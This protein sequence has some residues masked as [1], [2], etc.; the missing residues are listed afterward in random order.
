VE[1][2]GPPGY[3]RKGLEEQNRRVRGL[4]ERRAAPLLD[5]EELM[6]KDLRW[7]GDVCYLSG[8]GTERFLQ[9]IAERFAR[10]NRLGK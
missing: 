7:Y 9:N 4:V 8:E 5:Q 2:W 1:L 3:V 6:G 10:E